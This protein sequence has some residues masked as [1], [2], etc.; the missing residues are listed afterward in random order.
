MA[1]SRIARPLTAQQRHFVALLVA[2]PTL[3]P[4]A[5]YR[6][7][8]P[9]ATRKSA[10]ESASRLSRDVRVTALLAESRQR[11]LARAES[12]ADRVLR[13]LDVIGFSNVAH[14]RITDDGHVEL[15]DGAPR[16]AIRA[17]SAIKRTVKRCNGG[18]TITT[19]IRLWPKVEALRLR[20]QV[21]QL[22]TGDK[23]EGRDE[24]GVLIL[25]PLQIPQPPG[26][27]T[28]FAA[29]TTVPSAQLTPEKQ[30]ALAQL[31]GYLSQEGR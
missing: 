26:G 25:P 18:E 4:T 17:V 20:G 30:A 14:Y 1:R 23:G 21:E 31:R 10:E 24:P 7:A 16:S 15:T 5:A 22:F 2:D 19:E 6:Q 9:R 29:V 27:M 13:E 12:K 3:S 8:Y 28:T 11:V